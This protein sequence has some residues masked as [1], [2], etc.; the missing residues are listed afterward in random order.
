MSQD[1]SIKSVEFTDF[2]IFSNISIPFS[3]HIN[4]ISGETSVGKTNIMKA[5]TAMEEQ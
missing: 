5:S 2:T 4:I 3:K 1:L